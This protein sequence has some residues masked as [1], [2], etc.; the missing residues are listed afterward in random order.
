MEAKTSLL[1]DFTPSR[2][3]IIYQYWRRWYHLTNI[4]LLSIIT[5]REGGKGGHDM[6]PVF[7]QCL[8]QYLKY[9][10]SCQSQWGQQYFMLWSAT[11]FVLTRSLPQN[12]TSKSLGQMKNKKGPCKICFICEKHTKIYATKWLPPKILFRY[13]QMKTCQYHLK[14]LFNLLLIRPIPWAWLAR[15]IFCEDWSVWRGYAQSHQLLSRLRSPATAQVLTLYTM[16][17]QY[18]YPSRVVRRTSCILCISSLSWPYV[19]DCPTQLTCTW[20]F[21]CVPWQS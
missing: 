13:C 1:H 14:S 10:L 5:E 11:W 8:D 7:C 3:L 18:P 21:I 17:I 6:I 4:G 2:P 15:A 12:P 16:H 20:I 19:V 9:V